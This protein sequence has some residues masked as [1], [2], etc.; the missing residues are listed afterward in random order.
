MYEQFAYY[1]RTQDAMS[2]AVDNAEVMLYCV[3]LE[4]KESANVSFTGLLSL[5]RV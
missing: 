1:I 3:S 5:A 2:D 4:Y